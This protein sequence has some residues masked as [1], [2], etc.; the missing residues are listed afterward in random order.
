MQ[1]ITVTLTELGYYQDGT[2][3][4]GIFE[5][6]LEAERCKSKFLDRQRNTQFIEIEFDYIN[7]GE[8]QFDT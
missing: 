1:V 2:Q 8:Y 7:L 5:T 6:I 4:L 3:L